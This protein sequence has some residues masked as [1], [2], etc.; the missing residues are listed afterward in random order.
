MGDALGCRVV[1]WNI[2][3]CVGSDGQ[4]D[5]TRVASV[6]S[7]LD[8][9]IIGLQEVDWRSPKHDGREMLAYLADEL[10]MY[11]VEGPNL[12]DH[13]GRYGNGLLTRFDVLEEKQHSL[14]HVGREPRGAIEVEIDSGK[15][16]IRTLVTHLGLQYRER[17]IQVEKLR[18]LVANGRRTDAI[19]LLGDMNEW[20]SRRLMARAFTPEPFARMIAGRTFPSRFPVFPL[21]CIFA[22]PAP[23]VL[24]SSV[25]RTREARLASDHLPLV[26]DFAWPV[27]A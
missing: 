8:A 9:D 26:A 27:H 3:A 24:E 4:F 16:I 18:G 11:A 13:R 12:H 20:I 22:W 14:A 10:G 19:L 6:L 17:R 23:S 7:S 25:V 1:T 21:D 15:G 2:H 5:V